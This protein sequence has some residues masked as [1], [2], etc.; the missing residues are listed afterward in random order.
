MQ[1]NGIVWLQ[2][3]SCAQPRTVLVVSTALFRR[4]AEGRGLYFHH[5]TSCCALSGFFYVLHDLAQ[6][7][8]VNLKHDPGL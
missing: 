1:R 8:I 6:L 2:A 7:L 3:E 4:T 5:T